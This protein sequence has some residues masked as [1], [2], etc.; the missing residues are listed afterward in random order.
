[1]PFQALDTAADDAPTGTTSRSGI[2][3]GTATASFAGNRPRRK[4]GDIGFT[5]RD[6]NF[7]IC[8]RGGI[9]QLGG[10]LLSQRI[11][12]PLSN[13]IVDICENMTTHTDG[14]TM[15][16]GLQPTADERLPTGFMQSFRLFA[17]NKYADMC[18][19]ASRVS[20]PIRVSDS[21]ELEK[22][23]AMGSIIYDVTIAPQGFE[24]ET[25]A[26]HDSSTLRMRF[27]F[28]E[29]GNTLLASKASLSI[30][31]QKDIFVRTEGLFSLA[32]KR[33]QVEATDGMV[34]NGGSLT[35]V[36]GSVVKLGP[37][38]SP[39]AYQGSPV[40]ILFP[41]T[42]QMG[43]PTPFR[44]PGFITLGRPGVLV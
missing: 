43:A 35:H 11:C 6:G 17:D 10:G 14:G 37:G 19:K 16:W 25:G 40:E 21:F 4:S 5:G 36:K 1:M 7:V 27:S 34:L 15:N 33:V 20:D 41:Y 29:T 32:T 38:A 2:N 9:L 31:F 13:T 26:V 30:H 23:L 3:V 8:H 28:D 44:V 12:I 22:D 18:I 39:V 24:T 42:P